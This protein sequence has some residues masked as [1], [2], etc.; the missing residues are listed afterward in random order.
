MFTTTGEGMC[1]ELLSL[2]F[3]W[4]ACTTSQFLIDNVK[5]FWGHSGDGP[6]YNKNPVRMFASKILVGVFQESVGHL[7][8]I[9]N[10]S[11]FNYL[12]T[13]NMMQWTNS[14]DLYSA[15]MMHLTALFS[16]I[17]KFKL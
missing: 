12:F 1:Q 15:I 11:F 3:K 7:T 8:D 2:Y 9:K 17:F 5:M 14:T 13:L 10:A 6:I 16:R 4:D